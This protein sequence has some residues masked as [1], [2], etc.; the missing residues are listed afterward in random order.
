MAKA[1]LDDW[2]ND[3][4]EGKYLKSLYERKIKKIENIE[5]QN[6]HLVTLNLTVVSFI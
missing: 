4:C 5:I 1:M 3:T 2:Q 6:M